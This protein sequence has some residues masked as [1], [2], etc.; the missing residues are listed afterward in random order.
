MI[1]SADTPLPHRPSRV[2]VNGGSGA[3]KSTL[4]QQISRIL[5]LPYTEMDSLFHGPG[6]TPKPDFV[7]VVDSITSGPRWVCEYQYD[8]VRPM[9][10][11]RADLAVWLDLPHLVTMSRVARRTAIRRIRR[12]ELWNGNMEPPLREFFT[13]PEH[14]V[15]YAWT[16][17]HDPRARA[18]GLLTSH[19][20]L[21][22]VRL[23]TPR[24]VNRW[25]NGPLAGS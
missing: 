25:V 8:P 1:L 14:V 23:R 17:R 7:E 22:V 18:H 19:P 24:E 20:H 10:A 13:D 21:P 3:G 11:E 16:T 12:Q 5:G 4:S 15:R 6:W 9:L 2:V